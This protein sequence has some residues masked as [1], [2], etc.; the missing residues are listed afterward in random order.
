MTLNKLQVFLHIKQHIRMVMSK[1]LERN[2]TEVI[3]AYLG[4][5]LS[6]HPDGLRRT[7]TLTEYQQNKM[8]CIATEAVFH[9]VI[10]KMFYVIF[11]E[12]HSLLMV[13]LPA[14]C[15]LVMHCEIL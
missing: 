14:I 13:C 8:K 6:I 1:E 7:K 15:L 5:N 10:A 11:R 4:V 9:F 3:V 2:R 12:K